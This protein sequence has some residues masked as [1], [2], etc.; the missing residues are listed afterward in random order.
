ML[1]RRVPEIRQFRPL[2]IVEEFR[3]SLS[4]EM[5]FEMELLSMLRYAEMFSDEPKLHVPTPYP[6]Y[7]S[8]RVL[9]MEYARRDQGF[10]AAIL[11]DAGVDLPQ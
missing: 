2:A 4:R 10:R 9:V 6:E 8:K 5:D 3:R 11:I 7:S 1:E